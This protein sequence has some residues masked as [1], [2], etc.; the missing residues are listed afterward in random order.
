MIF[1]AVISFEFFLTYSPFSGGISPVRYDPDI[2]MWHKENFSSVYTK[3]CYSTRYSFDE[4]GLVKNDYQFAPDKPD[5]AVLGDSYIEALM[6]EN[7]SILH[8]NLYREYDGQFNFLN[9]SLGGT[10]PT[11]HFEILKK[12]VQLDRTKY[13]IEFISLDP[14]WGRDLEEVDPEGFDW[15]NRPL[16]HLKFST[17]DQFEIIK[18][19]SKDLKET[20]REILANFELYGYLKKSLKY[21]GK[22]FS[23]EEQDSSS[24]EIPY[25]SRDWSANWL[26]LKGA[27][28]QINKLLRA[29]QIGHMVVIF[30][31]DRKHNEVLS[32]FLREYE[33]ASIDLVGELEKMQINLDSITFKCDGHWTDKTHR[34]FASIIKS[35]LSLEDK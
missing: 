28:Y 14:G 18:P 31:P 33:I 2:G 26:Q 29:N 1:L 5:V 13:L 20:I 25:G 7:K 8:N 6:V 23:A 22:K 24:P 10:S 12:M 16:I 11:Q 3:D 35:K 34:L 17:L 15:S 9:F 19:P 4:R 32:N 21:Y 30:S 27:V